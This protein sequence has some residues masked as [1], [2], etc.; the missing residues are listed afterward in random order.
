L[1]WTGFETVLRVGFQFGVT[2]ALARL[3]TPEEFG[4]VAIVFVFTQM[5]WV[6]VEAGF[7]N[8]LVQK[9]DATEQE[10]SAIFHFQ[11]MF[12]LV[13]AL[14]LNLAAPWIAE[15]YGH[16]ILNPLTRVLALNLFLSA[17]GGVHRSLLDRA[18]A[19]RQVTIAGLVSSTV[20]GALAV[21][22]AYNGAGVWALAVQALATTSVYVVALW[23][24]HPWR[25]QMV[26]RPALLGRTFAFGRFLL[27]SGLLEA[28]YG[29]LYALAIGKIYGLADLGQ[30]TRAVA[31]QAA[32]TGMLTGILH[33]VAFPAFAA[34]QDDKPRIMA[35]LRKGTIG[36]MAIN[37]PVMLGLL[38]V[39]EPFFLTVFGEA[40]RPAIPLFR[41]LCVAG[42]VWPLHIINL[43][44]LVATG[45]GSLF[46][47]IEVI[48]KASGIILFL[49][50]VPF[51]LEAL[52]WSQVLYAMACFGSHAYYT[53]RMFGFSGLAQIRACSPWLAAGVVM[54]CGVWSLQFLLPFSM[55]IILAIQVLFGMI[56]YM[57]FWILWD[58]SLL[59]EVIQTLLPRPGPDRLKPDLLG[60]GEASLG[61]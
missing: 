52:A 37:I 57:A 58:P 61:R 16:P 8:A 13:L 18:L 20:A 36:V 49:M 2:V 7:T 48:K 42:L 53:G 3:L 38:A 10:M 40:W 15:F 6:L 9:R 54:A 47:R 24:S 1:L 26:F 46:F 22:L 14:A 35:W 30:Y 23:L 50:A 33:R 43:N 11:W 59:R 19:F 25:P 51:G 34:I 56:L 39:A 12:A 28:L 21:V 27:L 17:L 29:R 32:P 31:T 55:P 41:I 44:V 45:H 60:D 5:G 4:I